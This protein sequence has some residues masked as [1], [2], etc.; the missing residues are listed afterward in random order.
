MWLAYLGKLPKWVVAVIFAVVF[1]IG[2]IYPGIVGAAAL[3]LIV[4]GL[5]VLAF[6][7]WP[8]VTGAARVVRVFVIL[9]LLAWAVAKLVAS[10][11]NA[12]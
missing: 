10:L 4:V 1:L 2:A 5:L 6:V 3:L 9:A 11:N 7:T 8:S 12:S